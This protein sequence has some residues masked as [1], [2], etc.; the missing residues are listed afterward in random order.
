M[1]LAREKL[2]IVVWARCELPRATVTGPGR[3]D[4]ELGIVLHRFVQEPLKDMLAQMNKKEKELS[5][6][7]TSLN[8]KL[9]VSLALHLSI[10]CRTRS[11]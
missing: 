11:G 4:V 9:T 6:D 10:Y 5:D 2:S 1:R 3:I 7:V 8:K